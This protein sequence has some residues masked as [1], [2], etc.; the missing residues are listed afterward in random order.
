VCHSRNHRLH[1]LRQSSDCRRMGWK[2]ARCEKRGLAA[3]FIGI[4]LLLTPPAIWTELKVTIECALGSTFSQRRV[5]P[6][7]SPHPSVNSWTEESGSQ[8]PWRQRLWE[9]LSR[10][11]KNSGKSCLCTTEEGHRFPGRAVP[12]SPPPP[13]HWCWFLLMLVSHQVTPF[14]F[15]FP[16]PTIPWHLRKRRLRKGDLRDLP[17]PVHLSGVKPG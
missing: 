16:K 8:E 2:G 1:A 14:P 15:L 10:R 17:W 11:R 6:R 4:C 5:R 13:A 12:G 3:Y 7:P 9:A